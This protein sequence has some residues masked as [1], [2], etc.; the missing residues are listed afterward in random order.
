MASPLSNGKPPLRMSGAALARLHH[1]VSGAI[2]RGEAKPIVEKPTQDALKIRGGVLEGQPGKLAPSE[3]RFVRW[4][5]RRDGV[6]IFRN[7]PHGHDEV[8]AAR[9]NGHAGWGLYWRGTHWEF[10][11]SLTD[12]PRRA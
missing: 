5:G 6:A 7:G 3:Y 4:S 9:A 2:E 12:T 8:F 11:A 1:H 10:C